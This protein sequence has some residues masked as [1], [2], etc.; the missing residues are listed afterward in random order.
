[1]TGTAPHQLLLDQFT[2]VDPYQGSTRKLRLFQLLLL[3]PALVVATVAAISGVRTI[4]LAP[5]LTATSILT[6]LT[7]TMALR[8]WERSVDARRDPFLATDGPR[9]TLL[10]DLRAHLTWTVL[11]GV[12]GTG[13]LVIMALFNTV[14]PPSWSAW[15]PSFGVVGASF[16][17]AYQLTLVAG[18]LRVFYAAAYGLRG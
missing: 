2:Q 6:G 8:F 14:T 17:V 4:A 3:L 12:I 13:W 18:A 10:D 15:L 16:L 5:L 7:F 11:I 9:L 1:M